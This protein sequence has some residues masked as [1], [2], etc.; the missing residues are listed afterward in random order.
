[1]VFFQFGVSTLGVKHWNWGGVG[2]KTSLK[3]KAWESK[4]QRPFGVKTQKAKMSNINGNQD[5]GIEMSMVKTRQ[6][7][8]ESYFFT[9]HNASNP[10]PIV[11]LAY[12]KPHFSSKA[13]SFGCKDNYL[14]TSIH[15]L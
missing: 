12:M 10:S 3:S 4:C 2:C 6:K 15:I 1:L 9:N 8:L 7:K 14:L 5:S 13:N 11:V